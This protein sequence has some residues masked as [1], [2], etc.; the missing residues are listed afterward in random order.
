MRGAL[1][2]LAQILA[3]GVGYFFAFP[4]FPV[5]S[6]SP[7]ADNLFAKGSVGIRA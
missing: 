7:L 1:A 3:K 6:K 5:A 2:S 4:P